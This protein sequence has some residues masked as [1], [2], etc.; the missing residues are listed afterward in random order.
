[1]R[2]GKVGTTVAVAATAAALFS[3]GS[4]F[5]VAQ[6]IVAAD[7]TFSLATYAMDQGD[8]PILQNIGFNQ[9][10]ATATVNGPD[11]KPLFS[12]PTIGTGSTT[13]DGTQYLT[14][15]AYTF[16]CTVHPSTMIA[17]LAVSANGI[18]VPRPALTLKLLS[19]N[20]E[21]V[22]KSGL[23]VRIDT[24]AKSDDITIEA[25]LG[26]TLIASDSD[27]SAAQGR[28]FAQ[29]RLNKAGK[30]KLRKLEKA[31]I[32]LSGTIPSGAPTTSRG[33]LK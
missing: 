5:G 11:G 3:A 8:K 14:T 12:S 4:A 26:K 16:I 28:T 23:L 17:T 10:N 24:T 22:V 20:I 31:T 27:H 30:S 33:K 19:R 7:N 2:P 6:N 1:M 25:R 9:H 13:L 32:Q 29:L 15:G 18:P 21:K